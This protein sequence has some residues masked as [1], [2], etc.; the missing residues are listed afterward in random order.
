[1]TLHTDTL[2]FCNTATDFCSTIIRILINY[3]LDNFCH[4]RKNFV[5][6]FSICGIIENIQ[7][8][9][10]C[11]DLASVQ[12]KG[13]TYTVSHDRL[14]YRFN[15]VPSS[16]PAGCWYRLCGPR[17]CSD[18]YPCPAPLCH[19]TRGDGLAGC[20]RNPEAMIALSQLEITWPYSELIMTPVSQ[21]NPIKM[22]SWTKFTLS[23]I[24]KCHSHSVTIYL[25]LSVTEGKAE[26]KECHSWLLLLNISN[27]FYWMSQFKSFAHF[28]LE[29]TVIFLLDFNA[30]LIL[31]HWLIF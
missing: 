6:H 16:L 17:S 20:R 7:D 12:M 9:R 4:K 27:S 18:E 19:V 10:E 14:P 29:V 15:C 8:R 21:L 3:I 1:M 26:W 25:K 30:L 23:C 24:P 13:A 5:W 11:F 28:F 2:V 22:Y 31:K